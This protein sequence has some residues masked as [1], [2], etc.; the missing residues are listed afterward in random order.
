MKALQKPIRIGI[1]TGGTFTDYVL[2]SSSGEVSAWKIPTTPTDPSEGIIMG[3]KEVMSKFQFGPPDIDLL[4]HGTTIGTNAFLEGKCPPIAFVTTKGFKDIIEIGRQ[5]RSDLYNLKFQQNYPLSFTEDLLLEVNERLDNKGNTIQELDLSSLKEA[6]LTLNSHSI[7]T[8]AVSLLFSFLNPNHEEEVAAFLRDEGFDVFPSHKICPQIREYERAVTTIVNA[9]V[10]PVVSKY[11]SHLQDKLLE[12]DITAPLLIMQSNTGMSDVPTIRRAGIQTL[13]SGLAGGVL[14]A[15]ESLKHLDRTHLVSL[16]IGGTSTDVSALVD[17]PVILRSRNFSGFPLIASMADVETIGSGG[18]SIAKFKDG[19]LSVGPE[20]QGA[21]PGPACYSLGGDKVTL[22]DANMYLGYVHRDN[23]AGNMKIDMEKSVYYLNKLL[24]DIRSSPFPLEISSIDELALS[25]RKILNNN[26]A[27]AIRVVTIQKGLDVRDY[28]L[29]AFGGAGPM[30]AWDIAQELEMES[31][32]I[33]PFPG[34][35]SAYGLVSS[36]IKHEITQSFLCITNNLSFDDINQRFL[37]LKEELSQI[38]DNEKVSKERQS[39][40]YSLDI[41]YLGQSD[42]LT[43]PISYPLDQKQMEEVIEH[44][45]TLHKKNFA[46]FDK[47]L[48]VEIVNLSVEAVGHVPGIRLTKLAIGSQRPPEAAYKTSRR[49]NF[50]GE[51]IDTPVYA[52]SEL[53]S[54]NILEGPCIIDQLD[55]TTAIP[56]DVQ[57]KV[58]KLGYIL[59]E[60]KK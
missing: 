1:D 54:G 10:S 53:L 46:W 47:E 56:P 50:N 29:L 3:L 35:W 44:F 26:I 19:L 18:G 22:T 32:I 59:L 2:V 16:D 23:F 55:T 20:S 15:A 42:F 31:V 45:H 21:N 12:L 6:L 5:Q 24:K 28:G 60:E 58:N 9:K 33:P 30:Q 43:L 34:T 25:I 7:Q 13:Y 36:N 8:I 38:L 14:A 52:K 37:Q 17:K 11:L 49:V 27:N 40:N 4:I 48:A 41:R 57:G 51:W 39:F